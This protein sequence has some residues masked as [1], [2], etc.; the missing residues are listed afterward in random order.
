MRLPVL[1]VTTALSLSLARPLAA[2]G[3]IRLGLGGGISIPVRSYS[4]LAKKGWLG[5][6]NLTF[7]PGASASLGFRLDALYAQNNILFTEGRQTQVG[8]LANLVFQF[9]ARRT[10][11]RFYIFGGGG[12]IRTK[13]SGPGFG[14]VTGTDPALN[15]GAGISFGVRAFA[16]FAEARYITISTSGT[17]PQYVPLTAGISFGGL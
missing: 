3:D 13:T 17:K 9:G 11:N 14:T 8:G 5:M 4:D 6:G 12:Y 10:P 2:Q 7:F 1:V 15:A 16:L